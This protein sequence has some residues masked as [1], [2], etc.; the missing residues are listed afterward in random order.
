M[1]LGH[2]DR[3]CL[4]LCLNLIVSTLRVGLIHL[5]AILSYPILSYPILSKS[6]NDTYLVVV[7]AAHRGTAWQQHLL[8]DLAVWPYFAI[9]VEPML[10]SLWHHAKCACLYSS[11][12]HPLIKQG[13]SRTCPT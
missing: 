5:G 11:M 3:V 7:I 6:G 1:V 4:H 13:C 2:L 12:R 10:S 8:H 9:C